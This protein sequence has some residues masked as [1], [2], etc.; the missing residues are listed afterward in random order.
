MRAASSLQTRGLRRIETAFIRW[1]NRTVV[2]IFLFDLSIALDDIEF[3]EKLS[4]SIVL[5]KALV[6]HHL[7]DIGKIHERDQKSLVR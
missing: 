3:I 7:I 2:Q 5:I 1:L 4:E 6:M